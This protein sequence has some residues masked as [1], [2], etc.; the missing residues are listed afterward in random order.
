[1]IKLTP[2]GDN[3]AA[4]ESY[5]QDFLAGTAPHP[6]DHGSLWKNVV[7]IQVRPFDG[8]IHLS[9]IQSLYP[10]KGYASMAMKWL[11]DLADKHGVPMTLDAVPRGTGEWKIGKG[12]LV[13]FYKKFG[14]KGSGLMTRKPQNQTTVVSAL[15]FASNAIT[16]AVQLVAGDR[17][18]STLG[19]GDVVKIGSSKWAVYRKA[20]DFTLWAYKWPSKKNK[21]YTIRPS[22]ALG[23]EVEVFETGGSGQRLGPNIATGKLTEASIQRKGADMDASVSAVA[24]AQHALAE[25][26]KLT[27][28]AKLSAAANGV[29]IMQV[30]LATHWPNI[31]QAFQKGEWED[32]RHELSTIQHAYFYAPGLNERV[33]GL[34]DTRPVDDVSFLLR[35][36]KQ[37]DTDALQR[38]FPRISD[39]L[40]RE[41][42][43]AAKKYAWQKGMTAEDIMDAYQEVYRAAMTS[44][45]AAKSSGAKR[46]LIVD[47]MAA[48]QSGGPEAAMA[49]VNGG[50]R[51]RAA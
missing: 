5:M 50:Q 27:A 20:D 43:K 26:K 4:L 1:M 16:A 38:V 45:D 39:Q 35:L 46:K 44:T 30:F 17:L 2:R 24:R 19:R 33:I 41:W 8:G 10:K 28:G 42:E 29:T 3:T 9:W 14:F 36:L 23:D 15:S 18:L 51:K 12:K 11:T 31:V 6:F 47:S 21:V 49:V 34:M 32:M 25:A 48:F 37:E 7:H 13:A 40:V 22:E